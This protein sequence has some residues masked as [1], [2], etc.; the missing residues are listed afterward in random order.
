MTI[1]VI[2]KNGQLGSQLLARPNHTGFEIAGVGRQECDIGKIGSVRRVIGEIRPCLVINAAAYTNVDGAELDRDSAFEANR[3]GPGN[4]ASECRKFEI[5]MIHISTD[6]VFDGCKSEPYLETDPVNPVSVYGESKAGGEKAAAEAL[7]RLIIVRTSWFYGCNGPNFVKTILRLAAE[8]DELKIVDDQYGCPTTAVDMADAV[9]EISRR[10]V[11]GGPVPWGIYHYS[12]QGE[13]TWRRFADAIV[14]CAKQYIP[15]QVKT[16]HPI[17]TAEYPTPARR[18]AYSVLNCH[19]IERE[20]GI[21]TKVWKDRLT[22]M[23]PHM[24][25]SE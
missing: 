3:D 14:K 20:F 21:E 23:I 4:L 7:D 24:I 15:L 5:P 22:S 19:R 11:N 2:G 1:L 18:P 25:E 12:G 6:Y 13:T 10:I 17:T 16:I 9:L 8:R